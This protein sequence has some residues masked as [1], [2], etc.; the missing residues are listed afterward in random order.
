MTNH[1]L[2]YIWWQIVC[3]ALNFVAFAVV[4]RWLKMPHAVA[5]LGA[6]LTAFAVVHADQIKHSQ[7]IPRFFMPF[8]AYY[9]I[10][11]ALEPS[12]KA[13]NGMLGAVFFQCLACVYTGW[14]LAVGIAVFLPLAVALRPGAARELWRYTVEHKR[15]VAGVV[16]LW[17]AA[18]AGLF[19]PYLVVNFGVAR[20]YDDCFNLFPT[21][22]A[23][24]TGPE[25]SRWYE[26]L[27][28]VRTPAPFECLLF[29]GFG[30]YALMLAAAVHLPLMPR[31]KRPAMWS[32][33]VAGLITAFV[34]VLLTLATSQTGDSLWRVAR[35]IPGGT[36]IRVVSRVYVIVYLFGWIG[37]L[38][39]LSMILERIERLPVKVAILAPLFAFIVW[40]QTGFEQA[41][42]ARRDFYPFVDRSAE[43]LRGAEVG[44]VIPGYTDTTGKPNTGPYGEVFGMW[45]GLR[46]NVPVLNGYSGRGPNDFPLVVALSDD[47]IKRWLAGKFRGTVR[48]INPDVP[49]QSAPSWWSKNQSAE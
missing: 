49:G 31:D 37:M 9:A 41:S 20:Q 17:T 48:Q 2:A 36:A 23:W 14:F 10:R 12:V 34:W 15:R 25:G 19:V 46:A 18:M 8:A 4:A 38:L 42:F 5:V 24:F 7:M 39:W 44:Y 30:V 35:L 22:A 27:G 16:A 29:C 1:E 32:A 40:E 45:V 11:L 43:T 33:A 26:T 21:P 13:L 47:D 3:C 6:F 28:R